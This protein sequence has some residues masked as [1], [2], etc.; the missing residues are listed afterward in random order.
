MW[1]P[2]FASA[3]WNPYGSGLWAWY[4]SAG[5]SWVSP[6]PWGWTPYHY[7]SWSFCSGTGWGWTP[8]GSW[9]GLSNVPGTAL[10][11][12]NGGGRGLGYPGRPVHAPRCRRIHASACQ[13]G[14]AADV[15]A[16]SEEHLRLPKRFC[17][18][19]SSS[20]RSWE[21]ESIL[22]R[23]GTTRLRQHA[24]FFLPH[25]HSRR[26]W[27]VAGAAGRHG[28]QLALRRKRPEF[29]WR[30]GAREYGLRFYEFRFDEFR[31][32]GLQFRGT[33][34]LGGRFFLGWS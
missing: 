12:P 21:I 20:R 8:G 19:G 7:G 9:M 6:Y 26:E 2:Y 34:R 30:R 13:P 16:G 10:T 32:D 15:Q 33:R 4:P 29:F 22:H 27:N 18:A 11:P 23:S 25:L 14:K 28:N 31:F 5:Y 3:S 24:R 17:W 1:R